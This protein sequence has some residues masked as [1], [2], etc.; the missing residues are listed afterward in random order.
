MGVLKRFFKCVDIYINDTDKIP[1]FK[2]CGEKW[3]SK[4]FQVETLYSPKIIK[5]IKLEIEPCPNCLNPTNYEKTNQKMRDG[6]L[7]GKF[8]CEGIGVSFLLVSFNL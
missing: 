6:Y 4:A 7:V 8:K 5:K 1:N 3:T 2:G